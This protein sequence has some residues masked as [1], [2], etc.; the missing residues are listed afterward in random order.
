M[1]EKLNPPLPLFGSMHALHIPSYPTPAAVSCI[2]A[3]SA[4]TLLFNLF[5]SCIFHC[6]QKTLWSGSLNHQD[7]FTRLDGGVAQD[8]FKSE[9]AVFP[10]L[11]LIIELFPIPPWV[12]LLKYWMVLLKYLYV[13]LI[14]MHPL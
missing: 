13:D 7:L 6:V 4:L 2:P 11:K 9:K 14:L 8:N 12:M 3:I 5:L 1:K 10:C